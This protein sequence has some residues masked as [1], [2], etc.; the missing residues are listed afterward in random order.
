MLANCHAAGEGFQSGASKHEK[1]LGLGSMV[2]VETQRGPTKD[3]L[4]TSGTVMNVLVHNSYLVRMD[5]PRRL[6]KLRCLSGSS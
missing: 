5:G 6:S 2:F 4:D 1:E 3:R